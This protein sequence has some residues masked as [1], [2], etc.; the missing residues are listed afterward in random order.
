MYHT[1][2]MRAL[3]DAMLEHSGPL[4][5]GPD[6]WLTVAVRSNADRPR[7]SAAETDSRTILA[8]ISGA[9]LRS[10]RSGQVS[11]EEALKR[12]ELRVF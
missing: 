9:G 4:E 1:E 5:I 8:R 12:I 11:K 6:E 7:I 10:F 2:V 3:M